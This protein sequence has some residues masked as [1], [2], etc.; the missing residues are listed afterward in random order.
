MAVSSVAR[1][2]TVRTTSTVSGTDLKPAT[3][4]AYLRDNAETKLKTVTLKAPMSGAAIA[5]Q[6]HLSAKTAAK[7][8]DVAKGYQNFGVDTEDLCRGHAGPRQ[9]GQAAPG[10]ARRRPDG[11]GRQSRRG[12]RARTTRARCSTARPART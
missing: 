3:V 12:S 7:V 6:L 4:G 1:T 2:H 11:R 8:L 5:K 9:G 10:G